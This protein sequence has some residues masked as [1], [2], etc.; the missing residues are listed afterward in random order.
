MLIYL[1]GVIF[2]K[3]DNITRIEQDISFQIFQG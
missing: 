2:D 1:A 3:E